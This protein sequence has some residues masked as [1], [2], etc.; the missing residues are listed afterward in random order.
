MDEPN[1]ITIIGGGL[2]GCEA[3]WQAARQGVSVTL[4]EMKPQRYSPAHRSESLGELVCSN[5]LRG[6]GLQ[7][8]VGCLKEE[9][10]RCGSLVMQ[11]A[12]AT[13]VPAG[14]ALA[15][16]RD[17]FAAYIT[18]QI[19]QQP[20]INLKRREVTSIPEAGRVIIASGPLT[21]EALAQ[22]V[23]RLTG[24]KQLYFYDAIAP[25]IEA[26]SINMEI[27]WK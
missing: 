6:I 13:T 12:D 24:S 25:I 5:S 2:A 10:R 7:G 22:E 9:L 21:S 3:A 23:A 1:Q 8:A 18:T 17:E 14:G 27:V 16:N 20:L 19:E 11:A 4:L 15:V 26:D